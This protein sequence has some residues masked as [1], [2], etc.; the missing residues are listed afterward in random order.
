MLSLGIAAVT[1]PRRAFSFNGI[2]D[3]EYDLFANYLT[4]QTENA[5]VG[6][7][8]VTVRGTDVTGV[9][10]NL[11]PLASI[12]GTITLD[13]IKPEDKCDKRGSQLIETI[14]SAPRDEPKKSGSPS[15]IAMLSGGLGLLNEK[16]EFALRNLEAARYRLEIKLPTES[17]YVRAINLPG[18]AAPVLPPAPGQ[19]VRSPAARP[20]LKPW[21]GVVTL[22][23]G[24]KLSGVLVMVGQ[25]AA[26]LQGRVATEGAAIREGTRVHLVPAN[27]EE[28]NDVLRYSETLVNSDGSFAFTNIAPGRYLILSR[29]E[30][31]TE[32][33]DPP[34]PLA[35]DPVVRAKLRRD[36]EAANTVLEL[37]PCQRMVDYA[38]KLTATQ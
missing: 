21:Q 17:W 24:E 16:G 22:K 6:T 4:S 8:R 29:V 23:S 13:P 35:L 19:P 1:D 15:M 38:L 2:A 14:P 28:A 32:T 26:G 5:V 3:G 27:R 31:L 34:R 25:D 30:T 33:D 9:E 12:T 36:A 20:S 11:T 18:T 10:L 37:K 7:K